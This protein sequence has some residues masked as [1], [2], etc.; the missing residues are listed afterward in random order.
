EG[1]AR[2]LMWSVGQPLP[3]ATITAGSSGSPIP[4]TVTLSNP[5]TNGANPSASPSSGLAYSFGTAI[6]VTF[7]P[8]AFA[9]AQPGSVL[10]GTVQLNWS[11][12]PIAVVFNIS[13][14]APSTRATLSGMT[15]SNLPSAPAG[16]T[17]AVTLYGSGFV[18]S[19]DPAQQT[20]VG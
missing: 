13:I 6:S 12:A 14:Q 20:T 10:S 8:P 4:F 7:Y 3:T 15:P 5:A 19:T 17:F 2:N 1:M 11:G 18:S 9:G 16:Q